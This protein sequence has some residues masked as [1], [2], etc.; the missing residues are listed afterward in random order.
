M[1]TA[2]Q[3]L[4][5][6]LR[7]RQEKVLEEDLKRNYAEDAVLL[8]IHGTHHGHQGV[9]ELAG[10]LREEA[11]EATYEYKNLQIEGEVGFLEWTG[12]AKGSVITDGADS[13]L[14]RND[15]I[16]TQTIHYVVKPEQFGNKSK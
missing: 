4:E 6:H 12:S 14:V 8:S 9:R 11:P 15:F 3:V 1:R 16:V 2:K 10:M 5:E 13:Y 7:L